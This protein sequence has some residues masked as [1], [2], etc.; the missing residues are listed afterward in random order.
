MEFQRHQL[1]L[2]LILLKNGTEFNQKERNRKKKNL[3]YIA[4]Q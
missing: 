1:D 4:K 3:F 2:N